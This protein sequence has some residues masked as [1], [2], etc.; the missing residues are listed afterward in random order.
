MN[1]ALWKGVVDYF[2][3]EIIHFM[4]DTSHKFAVNNTDIKI[5]EGVLFVAACTTFEQ[6]CAVIY[7]YI[8]ILQCHQNIWNLLYKYHPSFYEIYQ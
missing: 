8:Y 2:K 7:I 1:I 5:Q 6:Q 3:I 4:I